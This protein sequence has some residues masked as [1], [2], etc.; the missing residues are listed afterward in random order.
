M[1]GLKVHL[2]RVGV[3]VDY[4]GLFGEAFADSVGYFVLLRDVAG[5]LGDLGLFGE[6]WA[7]IVG[8]FR[9]LV[10]AFV[11]DFVA[12]W[13]LFGEAFAAGLAR[14]LWLRRRRRR[15]TSAAN[16]RLRR[17]SS[18]WRGSARSLPPTTGI[19]QQWRRKGTSR[20]GLPPRRAPGKTPTGSGPIGSAASARP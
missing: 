15:A 1:L 11:G 17:R 13:G 18:S 9:V 3:F 2:F 20:G 10:G 5:F 4:V 8:L 19:G 6:A 16:A 7:G 14:A 12:V